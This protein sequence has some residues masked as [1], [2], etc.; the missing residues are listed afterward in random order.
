MYS[1]LQIYTK[2]FSLFVPPVKFAMFRKWNRNRLIFQSERSRNQRKEQLPESP[3]N[4]VWKIKRNFKIKI[5][6]FIMLI[7]KFSERNGTL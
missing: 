7:R 3:F 1:A 2:I 6:L 4:T 5:L